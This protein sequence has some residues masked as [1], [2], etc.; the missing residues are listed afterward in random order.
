MGVK[1]TVGKGA[2]AGMGLG[3]RLQGRKYAP[4][5]TP[6]W[7]RFGLGYK[8]NIKERQKE[9][10]RKQERRKA[11]LRGEE[12]S[13]EPITFPKLS[14]SFISGGIIHPDLVEKRKKK[15]YKT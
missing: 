4:T 15:S 6:K 10:L 2:R 5:I 8:P 7:D 3:K 11:R 9:I 14:E 12:I 1:L 13:W